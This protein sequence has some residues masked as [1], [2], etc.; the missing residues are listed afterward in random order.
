MRKDMKAKKGL[1]EYHFDRQ[2]QKHFQRRRYRKIF[3]FLGLLS[4]T[5]GA[6]ALSVYYQNPYAYAAS[7][8]AIL[9]ATWLVSGYE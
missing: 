8:A 9:Y 6:I 4:L 3:A 2:A 5:S 7:I 1:F